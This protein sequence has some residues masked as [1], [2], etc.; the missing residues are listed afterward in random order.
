[1]DPDSYFIVLTIFFTLLVLSAFFSSAEIALLSLSEVDLKELRKK[2]TQRSKRTVQLLSNPN[3]FFI[4]IRFAALVTQILMVA[5]VVFLSKSIANALQVSYPLALASVLV[6]FAAVV[7][8]INEIWA[9]LVVLRNNVVF[10]E[11]VSFPVALYFSLAKPFVGILGRLFDFLYKK[12]DISRKSA[13]FEHH[14][15][16]AMVENKEENGGLE[17]NERAMIHS[18]FEFGDTAVHEI[19]V[20]RIDI[21]GV[22]E[23]ISLEE[24][25]QLIKSKGH[26]R[27]PLY[28]EGLDNILGIIH[29]KDLLQI[30]FNG[31]G[32]KPE[33]KRLARPAYFV[34]ETKKL[35]HLLKEFQ[36]EKQ[37]MAI[38]VDEYGGTAGLVTLEDVIEEIVG[39]IQDEYDREPP[40][41]KKVDEK[42]FLVNAK[43]DLHELNE[44]LEMNLPTEGEYD[45]LGG[46]I[47]S[48]TGYVPEENE[49][50]NY[51]NHTFLIK[52]VDR[53]R[54]VRVKLTRNELVEEDKNHEGD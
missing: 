14:K 34:P 20:P 3:S 36:K 15:I 28:N 37:H 46:F 23:N 12:F 51:K 9:K 43:I 45:S 30:T 32:G 53:N 24:L 8:I 16:M 40:L 25:T 11:F 13:L 29:A 47:F 19:M 4:A 17:A 2:A 21:I 1:M 49:I 52:K 26:S 10:A 22:E 33:L 7:F 41:Y 54:I 35:H 38:V 31:K 42:S 6:L 39:E 44:H 50:V 5:T 18:I 48:L 27:I